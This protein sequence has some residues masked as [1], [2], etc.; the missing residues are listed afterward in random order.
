MKFLFSTT[1]TNLRSGRPWTTLVQTF[2]A[3]GYSFNYELW[4]T[5]DH[6]EH[7]QA[8]TWK[9]TDGGQHIEAQY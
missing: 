8:R 9:R 4:Q 7:L 5:W 1:R 6:N 3:P 2:E